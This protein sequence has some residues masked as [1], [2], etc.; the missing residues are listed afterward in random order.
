MRRAGVA[1]L[2]VLTLLATGCTTPTPAA[3]TTSPSPQPTFRC[4][5]AT[6]GDDY[7]CHED[8]YDRMVARDARYAEAERVYRRSVELL[9]L[10]AER[11]QPLD[12]ELG[13][14]LTGDYLASTTERLELLT[15]AGVTVSG[16]AEVA[17]VRRATDAADPAAIA[18]DVCVAPGTLTVTYRG[19]RMPEQAFQERVR[20]A[21]VDGALRIADSDTTTVDSC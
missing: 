11:R 16:T 20:F 17:W 4:T 8:E 5:P 9:H 6:G 10:L 1:V 15:S 7:L 13:S 12:D 14:L 18:L 3:V 19:R 21:E 2:G